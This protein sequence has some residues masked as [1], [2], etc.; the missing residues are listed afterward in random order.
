[1]LFV[2]GKKLPSVFFYKINNA[3]LC[4]DL[5]RVDDRDWASGSRGA[6]IRAPVFKL[7]PAR[8]WRSCRFFFFFRDDS[9]SFTL[10]NVN[11]GFAFT[12]GFFDGIMR[13]LDLMLEAPNPRRSFNKR[14]NTCTTVVFLPVFAIFF[15][16]PRFFFT[17]FF[18]F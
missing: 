5:C 17:S 4:G 9:T 12:C 7:A 18:F 1:M 13:G 16:S 15:V 6:T 3:R 8:L 2:G 14:Q 10:A 11:P